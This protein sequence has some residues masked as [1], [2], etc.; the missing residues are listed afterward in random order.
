MQAW[1]FANSLFDARQARRLFGLIGAGA[2][3][4]AIAGGVLARFLVEPVGGTVNMLLV[5]AALIL[6][7]AVIVAFAGRQLRPAMGRGASTPKAAGAPV[8]RTLPSD[9]LDART[10]GCWRRSCSSSPS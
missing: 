1:S 9:P 5:L 6:A 2:S 10:C 8:R 3:F 7:S 4:G